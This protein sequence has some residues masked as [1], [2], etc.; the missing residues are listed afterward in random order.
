MK[1]TRLKKGKMCRKF[2]HKM[3]LTPERC[4]SPKCAYTRR[5][6]PPGVHGP[7]RRR[8]IRRSE[9][10][11]QLLE[12]QKVSVTYGVTDKAL[13][14][15]VLHAVKRARTA[16]EPVNVLDVV[17]KQLESRLDNTIFKL[18]LAPSRIVA[19]QLIT[20][21]HFFVNGTRVNKPAMEVDTG[22]EI[23]VR[24]Q[25]RDAGPFIELSDR[26]KKHKTPKWLSLDAKKLIGKV[27]GEPDR[28]QAEETVDLAKVVEFYAR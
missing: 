7:R 3:Y 25:S 14:K 20:H 10:G 26:L 23:A 21:G 1:P 12:K 2:G 9:Y 28:E 4:A 27:V 6:Y 11:E 15:Q 13:R 22:D 5:S 16:D 19:R 8:H 17:A 24:P 18:G